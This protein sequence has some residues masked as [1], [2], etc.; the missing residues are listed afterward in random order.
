MTVLWSRRSGL[1]VKFRGFVLGGGFGGRRG[2]WEV[3]CARTSMLE[4]V[5]LWGSI[6][7]ACLLVV[8]VFG[9]GGEGRDAMWEGGR[10]TLILN[11][12]V[13]MGLDMVK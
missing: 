13:C 8:V 11:G 10:L 5:A 12:I 3:M 1:G 4:R 2:G 7:C 6:I 9:E